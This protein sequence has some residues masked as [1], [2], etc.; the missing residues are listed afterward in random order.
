MDRE[1]RNGSS[2]YRMARRVRSGDPENIEAAGARYYWKALFGA[3]FKRDRALPGVNG[4]LNYGYMV[5]R[6][7]MARSVVAT[8][9]HPSLSIHH[10]N[11]GNPM[12]LVDDLIEPFRPVVDSVVL[13]LLEEGFNEVDRTSKP[14]ILA[15]VFNA[16]LE[17]TE[18]QERLP[19]CCYCVCQ[20]LVKVYS[21][22][23]RTLSLPLGLVSA[24]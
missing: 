2:L 18:K 7:T 16:T 1:G 20:S 24:S 17:I 14:E 9:L 4:L 8:G 19:A 21:G 3:D 13:R 6:S 23:A 10:Q 12:R 5:L 22:D 15:G 11:E